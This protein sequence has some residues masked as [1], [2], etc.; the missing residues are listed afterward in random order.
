MELQPLTDD[1]VR[2]ELA[3]MPNE[4]SPAPGRIGRTLTRIPVARWPIVAADARLL[5]LRQAAKQHRVSHETVRM[6]MQRVERGQ[7]LA[8][9]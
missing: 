2:I 4:H 9:D 1:E 6:I 3:T 7:W 8:A 5:G